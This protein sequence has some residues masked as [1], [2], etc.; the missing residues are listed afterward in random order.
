MDICKLR[1]EPCGHLQVERGTVWTS[2]SFA[3]QGNGEGARLGIW[4]FL[5][6]NSIDKYP[7]EVP[8]DMK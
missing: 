1:G 8:I 5:Q 3:C 6:A 7:V 4:D 2:G